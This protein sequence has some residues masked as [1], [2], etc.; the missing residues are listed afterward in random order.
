MQLPNLNSK[1]AIRLATVDLGPGHGP[2]RGYSGK[3]DLCLII[4]T[5]RATVCLFD[6]SAWWSTGINHPC[7]LTLRQRHSEEN[8]KDTVYM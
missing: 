4:F 2:I 7:D 3:P 5:R 6:F 8:Q 1:F